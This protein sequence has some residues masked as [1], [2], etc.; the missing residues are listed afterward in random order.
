MSDQD[1]QLQDNEPKQQA[2]E[3]TKVAETKNVVF[4]EIPAVKEKAPE[5][6]KKEEPKQN[7]DFFGTNLDDH[8]KIENKRDSNDEHFGDGN[9]FANDFADHDLNN[10]QAQQNQFGMSIPES[11]K[12]GN[13]F[14]QSITKELLQ[15]S[16]KEIADELGNHDDEDVDGYYRDNA[17]KETAQNK[18]KDLSGLK[19]EIDENEDYEHQNNQA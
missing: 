19:I 2:Y 7:I 12:E 8:S 18:K 13:P 14:G 9:F 3:P 10:E 11:K 1:L 5:Q 4:N 6:K 16:R 17:D 15:Q